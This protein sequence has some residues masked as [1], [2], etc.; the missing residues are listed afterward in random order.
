MNFDKHIS[1]SV[2]VFIGNYLYVPVAKHKEFFFLERI[3]D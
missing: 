2:S 1:Y 3:K